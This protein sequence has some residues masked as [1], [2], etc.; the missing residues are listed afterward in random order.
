[1]EKI[2]TIIFHLGRVWLTGLSFIAVAY[3]AVELF[4][5][6]NGLPALKRLESQKSFIESTYASVQASKAL[7]EKRVQLMDKNAIDPDML[8][9]QV[10]QKLGYVTVDEFILVN[11]Q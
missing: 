7:V 2:H 10:R 5:S 8:E 11:H 3:F 1:M 9:E 4:E 6:E